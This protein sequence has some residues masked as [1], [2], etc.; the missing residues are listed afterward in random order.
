MHKRKPTPKSVRHLAEQEDVSGFPNLGS[1]GSVGLSE[2][3]SVPLIS[4]TPYSTAATG[5]PGIQLSGANVYAG[6]STTPSNQYPNQADRFQT[7]LQV[8]AA[9]QALS[10]PNQY[11]YP[12]LQTGAT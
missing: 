9:G 4:V 8:S 5:Y 6:M 12:T 1:M 7:P 11:R 3:T 2:G 10:A